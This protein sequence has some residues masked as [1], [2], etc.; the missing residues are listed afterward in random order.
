MV[1][2]DPPCQKP[3]HVAA[4]A[5]QPSEELH[6]HH[7]HHESSSSMSMS[8]GEK[9]QVGRK[10]RLALSASDDDLDETRPFEEDADYVPPSSSSEG[11]G[12]FDHDREPATKRRHVADEA[13]EKQS[14]CTDE[15]QLASS[16]LL[17]EEEEDSSEQEDDDDEED[18]SEQEDEEVIVV[19]HPPPRTWVAKVEWALGRRGGKGTLADIYSTIEQAFPEEV[20]GKRNWKAAIRSCLSKNEKRKFYKP[21]SASLASGKDHL[22]SLVPR[23]GASAHPP[24]KR[25]RPAGRRAITS[26]RRTA[27]ATRHARQA[28]PEVVDHQASVELP[29]DNLENLADELQ[30]LPA[31]L[32]EQFAKEERMAQLLRQKELLEQDINRLLQQQQDSCADGLSPD[33]E[34]FLSHLLA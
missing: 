7:H 20:D 23:E 22:W 28:A 3:T 33:Q 14:G 8:R 6:H 25:G 32:V 1:S 16:P 10:R 5:P 30:D 4:A 2:H 29:Q 13:D 12:D 11:T 27:A 34:D 18:S 9:K 31:V 26:T 17:E 24:A 19:P 21:H 15:W